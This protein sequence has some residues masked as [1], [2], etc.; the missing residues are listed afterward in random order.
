MNKMIWK[1]LMCLALC[2]LTFSLASCGDDDNPNNPEN[3]TPASQNTDNG[4]QATASIVGNWLMTNTDE[5]HFI[6]VTADG[7][8]GFMEYSTS[9][10]NYHQDGAFSWTRN[11]DGSYS[12]S[13]AGLHDGIYAMGIE[14]ISGDNM[15]AWIQWKANKAREYGDLKRLTAKASV[16]GSKGIVGKWNIAGSNDYFFFNADGMGGYME[17]GS[18]GYHQD[19]KFRWMTNPLGSYSFTGDNLQDGV[20]RM[21]IEN[22]YADNKD[23]MDIVVEWEDYNDVHRYSL[24]RAAE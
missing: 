10:N 1:S 5:P 2:A 21:Y 23:K 4:S 14:S 15:R 16:L 18:T 19:G 11:A 24:T 13:G 22:T 6:F 3:V 20:Y 8:G 7:A 12:F 9:G 17:H